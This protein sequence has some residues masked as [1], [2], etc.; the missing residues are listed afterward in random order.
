[1]ITLREES[2]TC[3]AKP[4]HRC[5]I[6]LLGLGIGWMLSKKASSDTKEERFTTVVKYNPNKFTWEKLKEDMK[7]WNYLK[8]CTT[9]LRQCCRKMQMSCLLLYLSTIGEGKWKIGNSSHLE[10]TTLSRRYFLMRSRTTH[11]AKSF[12]Y[13]KYEMHMIWKKNTKTLHI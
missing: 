1:M 6:S 4:V 12:M 11:I 10:T 2:V 13:Q 3:V 7:D 9:L 8:K 5:F